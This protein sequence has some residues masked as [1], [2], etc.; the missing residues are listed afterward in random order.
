M[1]SL[2]KFLI[3]IFLFIPLYL[4]AFTIKIT[5]H[6]SPQSLALITNKIKVPKDDLTLS[7]YIDKLFV[8]SEPITF[9]KQENDKTKSTVYTAE[10]PVDMEVF[11][12]QVE[13]NTAQ[14]TKDGKAKESDSNVI[15]IE[16]ER[17]YAV[18]MP[19]SI[20]AKDSDS[21]NVQLIAPTIFYQPISKGFYAF[22][23]KGNCI[24][25]AKGNRSNHIV[26]SRIKL[27]TPYDS[28]SDA[29]SLRDKTIALTLPYDHFSFFDV[30]SKRSSATEAMFN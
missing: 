17:D 30:P 26:T 2:S 4:K 10:I 15:D 14:Y 6:I 18:I 12:E 23:E 28:V 5:L 21:N 20:M 3:V 22:P 24:L 25:C 11:L 16:T 13:R 9:E 8:D 27:K 1:A 7:T 29:A 19:I